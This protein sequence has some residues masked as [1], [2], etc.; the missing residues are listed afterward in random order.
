M[1]LA[2]SLSRRI[3][4]PSQNSGSHNGHYGYLL[5]VVRRCRLGR[6][7][8]GLLH[9]GHNFGSALPR[10]IHWWAHRSQRHPKT[11]ICTLLME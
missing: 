8:Y 9:F 6:S 2:R 3:D 11:V 10:G 1:S 7:Q 5:S 4:P